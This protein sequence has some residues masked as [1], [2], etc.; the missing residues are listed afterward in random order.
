MRD[1]TASL[2]VTPEFFRIRS[3]SFTYTQRT[4]GASQNERNFWIESELIY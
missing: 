2:G 4:E 3:Q 1:F